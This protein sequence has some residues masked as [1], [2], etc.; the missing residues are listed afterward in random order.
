MMNHMKSRCLAAVIVSAVVLGGAVTPARADDTAIP[1]GRVV[2]YRN[3]TYIL[4]P[5]A[6]ALTWLTFIGL[7][8]VG[9][10]AL[11]LSAKRSH[12]D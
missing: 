6:T 2:G 4:A 8:V 5:S 1:E 10:G 7:S 9:A 11:F 12:L 3:N